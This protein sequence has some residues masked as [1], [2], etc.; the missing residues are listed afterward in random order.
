MRKLGN[1]FNTIMAVLYI[2]I[3]I[4]LLFWGLPIISNLQNK[5][6]GILLVAY[7]AFRLYRSLSYRPE[8]DEK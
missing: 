3:G 2:L 6:L 4:G 1:T 5:G 8:Q 7:G